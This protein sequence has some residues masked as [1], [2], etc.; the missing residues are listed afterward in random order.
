MNN[1][2]NKIDT[3][4]NNIARWTQ[5]SNMP[6]YR[7]QRQELLRKIQQEQAKL[8]GYLR[9]LDKPS[10]INKPVK[11][12]NNN[13]ANVSASAQDEAV[14]EILTAI[15]NETRPTQKRE[16]EELLQQMLGGVKATTAKER[17]VVC[18]HGVI[19]SCPCPCP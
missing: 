14:Q 16:L 6:Q 4:F 18:V 11:I 1:L 19:H 13:S 15:E 8:D 10:T 2:Q 9:E 17:V 12:I 7:T 5:E 3:S